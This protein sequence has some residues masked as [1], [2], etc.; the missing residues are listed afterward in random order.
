[1]SVQLVKIKHIMTK[2]HRLIIKHIKKSAQFN[3]SNIYFSIRNSN[4]TKNLDV[5]I[6]ELLLF[7]KNLINIRFALKQ[8]KTEDLLWT[9]FVCFHKKRYW[10]AKVVE[11]GD[12]S[13]KLDLKIRIFLRN[14]RQRRK[15]ST[16]LY[17][18][19]KFESMD[20]V[21]DQTHLPQAKE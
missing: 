19:T 7:T 16:Y 18:C 4:I 12:G 8:K 1:M 14:W 5:E 6:Y 17:R 13:L 11:P 3:N 20:Y 21:K 9:F 10:Q 2:L 15:L